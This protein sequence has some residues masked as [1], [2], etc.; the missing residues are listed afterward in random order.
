MIMGETPTTCLSRS[1][2]YYLQCFLRRV[3]SFNYITFI[4]SNI[5]WAML[6]SVTFQMHMAF[7][8]LGWGGREDSEYPFIILT[9]LPIVKAPQSYWGDW[10]S[11]Y[12]P[13]YQ[14]DWGNMWL[15]AIRALLRM[16]LFACTG[17][18]HVSLYMIAACTELAPLYS[19][20]IK[21]KAH[22]YN[23]VLL[24]LPRALAEYFKEE[25]NK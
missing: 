4:K 22:N 15:V 23:P 13:Y 6:S 5:I 8:S 1:S 16:W 3:L 14:H 18:E 9:V 10:E 12:W 20:W 24:S 25:E 7:F 19:N 17:V 11:V 21:T 2:V